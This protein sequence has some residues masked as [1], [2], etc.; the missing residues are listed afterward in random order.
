MINSRPLY[1]SSDGVWESPPVTPNDIL[2]GQHNLPPQPNSED[3]INPKSLLRCTQNRI[4]D[5]WKCWLKYF[6]PNLLPCN[7]WFRKR[8]NVQVGDLVLELDPKHKRCQWKMALITEVY[9]GSDGLV[10]KVK[11]G[12]QRVHVASQNKYQ[13]TKTGFLLSTR[14][15]M[16]YY[17]YFLQYLQCN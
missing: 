7:K 14:Q 9:P 8:E 17:L 10:R 11:I 4:A 5:F 13:L 15:S 6:A 2:L 3:R 1:P 12:T 16:Q